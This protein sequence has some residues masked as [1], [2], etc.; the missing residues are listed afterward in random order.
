MLSWLRRKTDDLFGRSGAWAKVR[1]EHL[2]EHPS[3]AACGR[4]GDIEV[5]HVRS[6]HQ[7]PELEL[8]KSNLI[9]LC[10]E[11]CHLVHG[12]L[13]SWRRINESVRED[14][15]AYLAKLNSAATLPSEEPPTPADRA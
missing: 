6:Y 2:A 3:C 1:R 9:S 14:C 12:H 5:H 11:P 4:T 13:M 7:F 15:A 8:E 10:A